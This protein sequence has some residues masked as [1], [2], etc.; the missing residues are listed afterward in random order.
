MTHA[1]CESCCWFSPAMRSQY[2]YF[3]G[4]CR[5]H[6]PRLIQYSGEHGAEPSRQK[7]PY[8]SD[9]DWCGEWTPKKETPV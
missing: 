3:P 5:R 2:D 4:E 7:W 8:V 9:A 6:E 1:T